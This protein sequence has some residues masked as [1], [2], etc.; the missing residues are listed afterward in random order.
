M[1]HYVQLIISKNIDIIL[2]IDRRFFKQ[3]FLHAL[4]KISH[5]GRVSFSTSEREE[6]KSRE[7]EKEREDDWRKNP[8]WKQKQWKEKRD[9][10]IS[11]TNATRVAALLFA[12]QVQMILPLSTYDGVPHL[13]TA[14]SEHRESTGE[15]FS[16]AHASTRSSLEGGTSRSEAVTEL[17]WV[18][19]RPPPPINRRPLSTPRYR[20]EK[21]Q[22]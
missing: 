3:N 5:L 1:I 16:I 10:P 19:R 18:N 7:R 6:K 11:L 9:D 21:L 20:V 14:H 13:L 12:A 4:Q 2:F 15:R 22:R 8:D 17:N